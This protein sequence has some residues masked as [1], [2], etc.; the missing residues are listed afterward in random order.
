MVEDNLNEI[1]KQ[2]IKHL[3]DYGYS[4]EELSL[5]QDTSLKEKQVRDIVRFML[6]GIA[7]DAVKYMTQN[8]FDGN[9]T[10]ELA[11]GFQAGFPL[12]IARSQ[13]K[14]DTKAINIRRMVHLYCKEQSDRENAA[15]E[16]IITKI[17]N[18]TEHVEIDR[19]KYLEIC[20]SIGRSINDRDRKI[21]ELEKRL[22]GADEKA[23]Q[24]INDEL[25]KLRSEKVQLEEEKKS[26]NEQYLSLQ[27]EMH[28]LSR[29][30]EQFDSVSEAAGSVITNE[31]YTMKP[32]NTEIVSLQEFE[33]LRAKY[34]CL[35]LENKGLQRKLEVQGE[36]LNLANRSVQSM[37]LQQE[38]LVKENEKLKEGKQT[39]PPCQIHDTSLNQRKHTKD[40][41]I[42]DMPDQKPKG[43]RKLLSFVSK[44]T[45]EESSADRSNDQ[46]K[47]AGSE[48]EQ[49]LTLIKL[50]K[51][52]GFPAEK[53][54]E[55]TKAYESGIA[56]SIIVKIVKEKF[57]LEQMQE[58]FG[59]LKI[60]DDKGE[61]FTEVV[62]P[63]FNDTGSLTTTNENH[64][65]IDSQEDSI[66]EESEDENESFEN[67]Q[68]D[69]EM[70]Y[71][72]FETYEDKEED[73]S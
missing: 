69:P 33:E 13:I 6:N 37:V 65:Q 62:N 63:K 9:Q 46:K 41:L 2:A 44:V 8:P 35:D 29:K 26:I 7:V 14:A 71:E 11:R 17:S 51:E 24:V 25:E 27:E 54:R 50:M 4:M 3:L 23:V 60:R 64:E 32:A 5:L 15:L 28:K 1:N 70:E 72:D 49:K 68:E 40:E 18:V 38:K 22:E 10:E 59:L 66:H 34:E 73:Y 45:E 47:E 58:V 57:S 21:E 48:I 20:E 42:H 67:Y 56:Y 36:Q 39:E 30:M 31:E 12:E 61:D 16:E 43:I 19:K 52:K 53:M 55:V